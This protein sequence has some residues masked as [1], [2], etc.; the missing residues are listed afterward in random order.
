MHTLCLENKIKKKIE[1]REI[2]IYFGKV[3]FMLLLNVSKIL[4]IQ[5]FE[6]NSYFITDS[7]EDCIIRSKI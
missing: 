4:N 1:E 3:W 7:L 6:I 2:L 5:H